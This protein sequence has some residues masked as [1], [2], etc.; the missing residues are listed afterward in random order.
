VAMCETDP[1]GGWRSQVST[2]KSRW[3]SSRSGGI[4][5]QT[6]NVS[7]SPPQVM[8]SGGPTASQSKLKALMEYRLRKLYQ[9]SFP[10]LCLSEVA[11]G[12]DSGSD[13]A[14]KGYR[15]A[16]IHTES[17]SNSHCISGRRMEIQERGGLTKA[18]QQQEQVLHMPKIE[19]AFVL[20]VIETRD[21]S[22]I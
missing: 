22:S 3:P 14:N 8:V 9:Q 4:T 18:E 15:Q 6:K 10:G 5:E 11:T 2:V 1:S 21:I 17:A 12:N 13:L 16:S 19:V 7:I 20:C